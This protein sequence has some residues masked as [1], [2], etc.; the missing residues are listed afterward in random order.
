MY[1]YH[2]LILGLDAAVGMIMEELDRQGIAD[3]TIILFAAD[4]GYFN[5]S[6]GM[7]GKLYAYEEASLSPTIIF[8]PR[9]DRG[10]F[11]AR[12]ETSDALTGN[13]DIAPTILEMAGVD[14][15]AGTQGKSLAPVL[16]GKTDSVHE[17]VMLLQ[18]WGTASAQS[19]A[20]VTQ[21]YKYIYWFY[22]GMNGFE[23]MEELFD[24]RKDPLE[25]NS[26]NGNPDYES[27]LNKM[28]GHYDEWLGVWA[29]Q[30]V[31]RN[32][33][34]KYVRLA[35]RH[36]PFEENDPEEIAAMFKGND[37]AGEKKIRPQEQ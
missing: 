28:R 25:Q 7:G 6:K 8:D 11:T 15:P 21:D 16:S 14:V 20:V 9:R 17:S 31:N 34:P 5:G 23:S 27:A 18:V 22:G 2:T 37:Q 12:F 36:R 26:V 13:I 30:G 4:N 10:A 32:G 1:K 24:L 35:D 3:N 29:E 33:Y 19:L